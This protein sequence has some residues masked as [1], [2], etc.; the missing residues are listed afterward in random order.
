M[1]MILKTNTNTQLVQI[2]RAEEPIEINKFCSAHPVFSGRY[3]SFFYI[4]IRV[5]TCN[6]LL[7]VSDVRFRDPS[8]LR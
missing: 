3:K 5:R 4:G 2:N 7:K 8:I 6:Q 1:M